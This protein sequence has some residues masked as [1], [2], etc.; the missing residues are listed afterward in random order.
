LS[1]QEQEEEQ[2]QQHRRV[3]TKAKQHL[4]YSNNEITIVDICTESVRDLE[5]TVQQ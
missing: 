3:A 1:R 4:Q 2:E 5:T